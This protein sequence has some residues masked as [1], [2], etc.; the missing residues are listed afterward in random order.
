MRRTGLTITFTDENGQSR[1]ESVELEAAYPSDIAAEHRVVHGLF[2]ELKVTVGQQAA[3]KH[4]AVA[5]AWLD[6]PT[7]PA[8]FEKYFDV[9]NSQALWLELTNL[10]MGAEGDLMLSAAFKALEPAQEPPFDD[11]AAINDLYYIH[12]RKMELLNQ[13]VHAL[14]KVQDLVNRLLHE[15]LGGDLVDTSKPDWE[16]TELTRANVKKGLASKCAGG[17]L[18][19][20]KLDAITLAL[21]IPGNTPKAELA[22]TYRNRLMH[23]IRPSVDYSQFFSALESRMGEEV[24]DA[25]GKVVGKRHPLFPTPQAE[26][27]FEDLH[28]AF[29]EYLDA[30][31]SM[32][33]QLSQLDILRR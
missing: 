26:Y 20:S 28:A 13:A 9:R 19:Q 1:S 5:R 3:P 25:Q 12:R 2:A 6:A 16:R 14:I 33:E 15:S 32:L 23:H 24:R 8:G 22:K 21:A 27:R 10:I 11:D 17:G 18:E 4:N 29:S 7:K 30:V 31:V